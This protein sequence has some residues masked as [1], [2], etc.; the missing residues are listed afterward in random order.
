MSTRTPRGR[1]SGAAGLALLDGLPDIDAADVARCARV[2]LRRPLLRADGPDGDLLPLIHRHRGLLVELFTMLLGYRLVIERRFA[3]LYKTGPGRDAT[4]DEPTLSPRGHAYVALTLACLTGA[5]RQLLLSRLVDDLR[6]AAAEAGIGVVD[7]VADR[8]ALTSALRFLLTLGVI[9]ETEGTVAPWQSDGPAEALLTVDTDLLGLLIS[10][11]LGEA[12][13][14]EELIRLAARPGARG[15]EHTVRRKLV[16]DPIVLHSEL[17]AEESDWLRRNQRRESLLLDRVFGLISETRVEGIAVTD[18]EEYLTDVV[19][20]GASTVSRITLLALPVLT[21][22]RE[23]LADGTTRVSTVEIRDA[24]AELVTAFPAAWSRAATEDLDGLTADVIALLV[25]LRLLRREPEERQETSVDAVAGAS[26]RW[27]L[28]PAA[29]RWLPQP[30]D[31]PGR[32]TEA[33][34]P[35]PAPQA[36]WSLFDETGGLL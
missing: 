27:L 11:P 1:G 26:P 35:R 15:V 2:L 12:D 34:A 5:G 23:P 13:S 32:P 20:P 36:D 4:R 31:T 21:D 8:R 33:P 29:H 30:D 16:E 18:P 28:S 7:D 25:R 19:F 3:R 10:G 14:P 6:A 17:S 24:C 9:S 22:L